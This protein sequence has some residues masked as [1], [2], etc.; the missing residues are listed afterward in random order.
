MVGPTHRL[1]GALA[2]AVWAVVTRQPE[3][4]VLFTTIAATATAYG[5][6]SPDMDLTDTWHRIPGHGGPLRHRGLTHW[7]GIPVLAWWL[8]TIHVPADRQWPWITLV[9]GWSSHLVGDAI[10]GEI[11]F[12]PWGWYFGLS[13][14]T[15]GMLE[16]GK[17]KL[18]AWAFWDRD[19]R[20]T[21]PIAPARVAISVALLAVLIAPQYLNPGL[22][23]TYVTHYARTKGWLA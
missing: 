15:D 6:T 1:F 11:P 16:S 7:W 20:W 13:L 14:D 22:L 5:A 18:P 23:G 12:L 8:V 2:G 19:R 9:L 3:D 10:F 4:V 21:L 17:I